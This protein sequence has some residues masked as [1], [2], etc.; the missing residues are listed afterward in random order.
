MS[1]IQIIL[2]TVHIQYYKHSAEFL[3]VDT[4]S[5]C[6]WSWSISA[7]SPKTIAAIDGSVTSF[8]GPVKVATI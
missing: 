7:S 4:S 2:F 6:Y 1:K 3:D 5:Q 8:V